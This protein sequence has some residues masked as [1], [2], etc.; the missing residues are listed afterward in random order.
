MDLKSFKAVN[1]LAAGLLQPFGPIDVTFLVKA[2]PKFHEDGNVLVVFRRLGQVFN[3][4]GFAG[5]A[6]DGDLDGQNIGIVGRL[7][8]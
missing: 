3:E 6:V 1:D 7:P 5:Q 8:D 4:L 2:G